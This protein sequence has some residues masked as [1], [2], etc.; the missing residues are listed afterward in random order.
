MIIHCFWDDVLTFSIGAI[1]LGIIAQFAK[2]AI[3]SLY[4]SDDE[5]E[6]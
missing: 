6:R 1:A 4:D 3:M 2:M 5:E